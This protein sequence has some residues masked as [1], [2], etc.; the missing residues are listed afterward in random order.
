VNFFHE[1]MDPFLDLEFQNKI[2]STMVSPSFPHL[3]RISIF[4]YV[5][6]NKVEESDVWKPSLHHIPLFGVA[7]RLR[8]SEVDP[9]DYDGFFEQILSTAEEFW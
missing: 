6:W 9:V 8:S 5:V 1:A 3:R 7:K 4:D 2:I